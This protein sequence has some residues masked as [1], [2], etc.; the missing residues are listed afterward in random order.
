MNALKADISYAYSHP[1][2]TVG[3]QA[4]ALF[5]SR[6]C[7]SIVSATAESLW[8]VHDFVSIN[9]ELLE[10]GIS[11]GSYSICLLFSYPT[12]GKAGL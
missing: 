8:R 2:R 1:S 4:Y 6:A 5:V 11:E 9:G 7:N 3:R 12:G 10:Y